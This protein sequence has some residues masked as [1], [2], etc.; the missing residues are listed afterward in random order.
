[1]GDPLQGPPREVLPGYGCGEAQEAEKVGEDTATI[2]ITRAPVWH[3]PSRLAYSDLK[4][5]LTHPQQ[6]R[7]GQTHNQEDPF[8]KNNWAE[9]SN[10]GWHHKTH[11]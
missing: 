5:P 11:W 4:R 2:P 6:R 9:V 10:N 8:G 3:T 7:Q 1:M